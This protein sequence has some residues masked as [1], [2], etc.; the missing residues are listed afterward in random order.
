MINVTPVD[1]VVR[2]DEGIHIG[3]RAWLK[4]GAEPAYEFGYGLGYTTWDFGDSPS[5]P[6]P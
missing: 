6:T 1:G 3:Y 2:Y 4:S 5:V